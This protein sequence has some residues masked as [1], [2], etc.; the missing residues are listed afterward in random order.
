MTATQDTM[1]RIE[2]KQL[3][4]RTQAAAALKRAERSA[5]I[6]QQIKAVV[7]QAAGQAVDE[8]TDSRLTNAWRKQLIPNDFAS[9]IFTAVHDTIERNL[10]LVKK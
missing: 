4:Q 9:D 2:A 8:C 10:E 5:K 7:A 6:Y 1:T 3:T